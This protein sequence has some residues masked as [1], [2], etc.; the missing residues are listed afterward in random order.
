VLIDPLGCCEERRHDSR[1]EIIQQILS[2][3]DPS[4]TEP[5]PTR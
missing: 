5:Q 3:F 1:E 4:A 2:V